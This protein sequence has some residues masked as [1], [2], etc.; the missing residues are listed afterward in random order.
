MILYLMIPSDPIEKLDGIGTAIAVA[1]LKI[2]NGSLRLVA[3]G[4]WRLRKHG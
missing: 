4:I 2:L 3:A 1:L